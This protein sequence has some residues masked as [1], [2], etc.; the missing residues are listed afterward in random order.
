MQALGR[1]VSESMDGVIKDIL[2]NWPSIEESLI[3]TVWE[4]CDVMFA[5][6]HVMKQL[7]IATVVQG[8]IMS[9]RGIY[10]LLDALLARMSEVGRN[11]RKIQDAMT[12]SHDY[13]EWESH[14]ED[15]DRLEGLDKWREDGKDASCTLF[16]VKVLKKRIS[17]IRSMINNGDIFDMMFRLRSGLARDQFGT[18]NNGLYS[19]AH[20]GT[21]KVI[22]DYHDTVCEGLELIASAEEDEDIPTDAKLAFFNET[23]HSYGRTALLLSG[24]AALGYYHMGLLRCLYLEKLLPRVISGAS[25]GSLMAAII[26]TCTDEELDEL[27]DV[28]DLETSRFRTDFFSFPWEKEQRPIKQLQY[29]LPPNMRWMGNTVVN[30]IFNGGTMWI[31]LDTEH[32]TEVVKENTGYWTFQEAFDRTGRIVNI[33]V[34]PQNSYDPPRLLNYLTAPHVCVW[35]AAVASCAIP[36][37]F[38][39]VDLVVKEPNGDFRKENTWTMKGKAPGEESKNSSSSGYTDGS[40]EADLPM[41]QLSELFNVNHFIVSQVNP[42]SALLSTLSLQA[43]IWSNPVYGTLV[44]YLR[45]LKAQCRDWLKNLTDLFIFGSA[46]PTWSARRGFSQLL[47]QEY[48]GRDEDITIMPWKGH[49]TALTAFVNLIKN[50][51]VEEY[52]EILLVG[53]RNT[54]PSIPRIRAH[55]RVERTL[56]ECVN[57]LRKQL[58]D[59]ELS[60]GVAQGMDRTPS[61]YTSRSMVNLS[62]LSIADPL[63][64]GGAGAI[65]KD[66]TDDLLMDSVPGPSIPLE[67]GMNPQQAHG[68]KE[69]LRKTTSMANFYY[70]KS[71][72]HEELQN[73]AASQTYM[74]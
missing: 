12:H 28:S 55:C 46:R 51:T 11:R 20:A 15:L 41:Q 9:M 70:K 17:D 45:F 36:G 30:S 8:G 2:E 4:L 60:K 10:K 72:S 47:T 49:Q 18:L 24:G 35:S 31:K 61:F 13:K 1:R 29:L 68:S 52:N 7:M 44:G 19:K 59:E 22:E 54:W 58:Y 38:D 69:S 74:N 34:S 5:P 3:Q 63:P 26:G 67:K 48:E 73:I 53:E 27:M 37:V 33:T 57:S 40:V 25:A 50:P 42:H 21:K 14:A 71:K 62:G 66:S 64:R 43:S 6:R 16:N 56:D 39:S 23:R 32:L 65:M